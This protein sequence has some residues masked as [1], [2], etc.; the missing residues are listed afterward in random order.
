MKKNKNEIRVRCWVFSD[1]MKFLGPG[2][3]ELLELIE[4]SGSISQAARTMGMSYKKAWVMID[5]MNRMGSVPYVIPV[6]GGPHGGGSE[7]TEAGKKV[8]KLYQK[9]MDKIDAVVVKEHKLL[10]MI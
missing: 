5:E 7:L 9:L 2:R 10:D 3:I 8:V 6:K 4:E 1:G